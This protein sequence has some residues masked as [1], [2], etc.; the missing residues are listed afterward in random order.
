MCAKLP[1][2]I[3]LNPDLT[4]DLIKRRNKS[5]WKYDTESNK[6]SDTSPLHAASLTVK[7]RR[8]GKCG[9]QIGHSHIGHYLLC[10]CIRGGI[11]AASLSVRQLKPSWQQRPKPRASIL[12]VFSIP[13]LLC[14]GI[15]FLLS[16]AEYFH[17]RTCNLQAKSATCKANREI[18]TWRFQIVFSF[19]F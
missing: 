4:K 11:W 19:C 14:S 7:R 15:P 12:S 9:A 17:S 13:S 3:S 10:R 18:L 8:M 1:P 5:K 6:L 2:V 16:R